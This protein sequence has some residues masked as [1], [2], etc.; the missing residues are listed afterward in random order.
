MDYFSD[1]SKNVTRA[2]TILQKYDIWIECLEFY[3]CFSFEKEDYQTM[4]YWGNSIQNR[5]SIH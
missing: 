5:I 3:N 1:F 2:F 4:N